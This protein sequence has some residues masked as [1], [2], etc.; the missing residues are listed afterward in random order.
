MGDPA[1]TTTGRPRKAVVVMFDTLCRH[2][3]PVY[4]PD[5]AGWVHAPNFE[6]LAAK[7]VTFD[8]A[9]VG[10]M[11]CMP[12]R[13]EMHTGRCVHSIALHAMH[14]I[15]CLCTTLCSAIANWWTCGPACQQCMSPCIELSTSTPTIELVGLCLPCMHP[16]SVHLLATR[17]WLMQS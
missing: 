3:L 12:A 14:G 7:T 13:R 6:R 1:S 16:T 11:P 4:S 2:F 17:K 10:S 8:N 5:T 9:F 15:T